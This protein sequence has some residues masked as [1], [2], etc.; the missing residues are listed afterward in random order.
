MLK[1]QGM[2][3][4][5]FHTCRGWSVYA[6]LGYI[7]SLCV[8]EKGGIGI[9][10]CNAQCRWK[11]GI[12]QSFKQAACIDGAKATLLSNAQEVVTMMLK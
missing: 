7:S 12:E 9:L 5:S 1:E 8:S 10:L 4:A 6:C 2:H 3:V 11:L